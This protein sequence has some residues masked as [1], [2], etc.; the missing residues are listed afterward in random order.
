MTYS[1]LILFCLATFLIWRLVQYFR[2]KRK[3]TAPTGVIP[4]DDTAFFRVGMEIV[5]VDSHGD[6]RRFPGMTKQIITAIDDKNKTITV[7]NVT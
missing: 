4:V 7:E 3:N 1:E 2:L 6:I 5:F